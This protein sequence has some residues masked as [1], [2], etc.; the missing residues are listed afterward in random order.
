MTKEITSPVLS[1]L[2]S[3][4]SFVDNALSQSCEHLAFFSLVNQLG[5]KKKFGADIPQILFVILICPIVKANSM[6]AFCSE[7][8]DQLSIG[9]KDVIYRFLRREDIRWAHLLKRLAKSFA[10]EHPECFEDEDACAFVVDDSLK[11][12]TGKVEASASHWDHNKKQAIRSHQVL[13]LGIAFGRGFIPLFTQICTGSKKR[14]QRAKKFQDNRSEVAK[15]YKRGMDQDKNS[16]LQ[17]MV[18]QAR[19]VGFKV[20]WILGDSWYGTKGNIKMALDADLEA[21]F[22]MKRS[23]MK[24]RFDGR[25]MNARELYQAFK[26]RMRPLG[27]GQFRGVSVRVEINLGDEKQPEW[28]KVTL[29]LS[30]PRHNRKPDGWVVCLCTDTTLSMERILKLYA[31][32]W[33]IEVFFKE[34]KQHLGWLNNQSADYVSSY[35]S[36][37]LGAIRY[38]LFL[39]G[40]LRGLEGTDSLAQLR[41]SQTKKLTLLNYMGLLWN[42][43]TEAIFGILDGLGR[44]FPTDLIAEIKKLVAIELDDFIAQAFQFD[45]NCDETPPESVPLHR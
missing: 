19:R 14:Q 3:L 9:A 39:D 31:L 10:L 26:R 6:W 12:R 41:K 5:L 45:L 11:P 16:M 2:K 32:R 21:I 18:K 22:L 15:A 40:A 29:M 17:Q 24:Y 30:R 36:L 4:G 38:L 13:S 23:A 43:L 20:K 27:G 37:H 1:T 35:A 44:R 33:S 7:F 25:L 34:C 8:L 28:R 42:L